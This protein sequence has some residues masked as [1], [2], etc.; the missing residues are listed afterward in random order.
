LLL[1]SEGY[2]VRGR[3]GSSNL[4][5]YCLMQE[6]HIIR[7]TLS[8]DAL[9][10]CAPEVV[11]VVG[12]RTPTL[13]PAPFY[14]ARRRVMDAL[15][16]EFPEARYACL[17]EFTTGKGTNSGGLRR[18]HWNMLMKGIPPAGAD[19]ARAIVR[20]VWCRHVDAI[21]A[22]QYV[23]PLQNTAA[24]MRYVAD[25]FT[26]T[27]Q[28]PPR[29]SR[30]KHKQRF[31]TSRDYY[32]PLTRAQARERGWWSLQHEREVVKAVKAGASDPVAAADAACERLRHTT[33]S[34][35]SSSAI[36]PTPEL[37]VMIRRASLELARWEQAVAA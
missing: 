15:K 29:D 7:R 20:E 18:P 5:E 8:L 27:S 3:C 23:E 35:Y 6:L 9:E 30:W 37:V 4:C 24:F 14:V 25:H 2:L 12:T 22:A 32:R 1:A 16:R 34:T 19:R 10:T 26:K 13:D 21:E 17:S 31:N 28:Q 36:A 33:W 11:V